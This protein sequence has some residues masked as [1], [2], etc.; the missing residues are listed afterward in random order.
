MNIPNLITVC[1]LF[2][3]PVVIWLIITDHMTAAFWLFLL[4]GISDG[5]D[6]FIAKR[7]G[8]QTL[9]G[10]YI[11]PLADKALLVSIYIAL[12][13][14]THIP[15]WLVIMVVS[16]DILIIGAVILSWMLDRAVSLKPLFISKANTTGQI[17]LAGLVLFDLGFGLDLVL[18]RDMLI[19]AVAILTVAS[20]VAYLI[21]WL[22]HMASYEEP[23][24]AAPPP[25][26][27]GA[28]KGRAKERAKAGGRS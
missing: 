8:M 22:D 7:F 15:N 5:I 12:G 10:A 6:G 21:V 4:A 13:L 26:R 27:S 1:R 3:V 9:L 17:L 19:V 14:Q 24:R 11:D 16:R 25:G 2:L 20:A 23:A 18:L 28:A